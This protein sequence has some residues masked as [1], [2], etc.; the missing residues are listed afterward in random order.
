M[1]RY[2]LDVNVVVSLI[3]RTHPQYM[4]ASDW[5][6]AQGQYDWCTCPIV[7]NGAVR[8]SLNKLVDGEQMTAPLIVEAIRLLTSI[9]NHRF[10]P[11]DI[12]MLNPDLF[13]LEELTKREHIT[14]AY[15]LALAAKNT[16]TLAT[17]DRKIKETNVKL[18][19]AAIRLL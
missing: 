7:E 17:F 19:G 2:L 14:D 8:V 13:E 18:P 12:S 11:E 1:T 16:A 6:L 15:L 3:D 9:G 4:R 5:F 10:L